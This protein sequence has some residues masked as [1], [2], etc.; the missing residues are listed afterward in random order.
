MVVDIGGGTTEIAV[1]SLGGIVINKSLRT[2]GDE[3]DE[4]VITFARMRHGI[5]I[6]E[7]TAEQTKIAIG[8]AY[9]FEEKWIK[10][11]R[12]FCDSWA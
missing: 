12:T 9:P 11:R 6:G 8:S 2:A 5:V 1:I 3:F 7:S 10:T 4:A